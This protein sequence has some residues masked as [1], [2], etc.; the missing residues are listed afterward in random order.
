MS[1]PIE[2]CSELNDGEKRRG[3]LLVSGAD[4]PIAFNAAAEVFDLVAAPAVAAVASNRPPAV[5]SRRDANAGPLAAQA[6][7]ERI[8]I[9]AF[10]RDGAMSTQ[11]GQQGLD[12]MQIVPSARGQAERHGAAASIDNGRKL[13]VNPAFGAADGLGGLSTS[14]IRAVLVQLDMR[15]VDVPQFARGGREAEGEH[16]SEKPLRAPAPETGVDRNPRTKVGWQ[17]PPR[18]PNAQNVEDR[19]GHE[20]VILRRRTSAR[21]SAIFGHRTVDFSNP[22]RTGSGSSQGPDS[23]AHCASIRSQ[24]G[25]ID[26]E[27]TA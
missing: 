11:T 9:A 20:P 6:R 27:F 23:C 4:A 26:F 14:W 24:S 1:E 19:T 17:I 13:C 7:A 21:A 22:S 10:V 8:G 3:E 12:R 2:H 5:L 15:T 16:P 25:S 18:N